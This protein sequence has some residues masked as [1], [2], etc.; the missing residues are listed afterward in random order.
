[1]YILPLGPMPCPR[2]RIALRGRFPTA[3]YPAAY[4]KWKDTAVEALATIRPEQPF[5]GPLALEAWFTAAR[6]KSTKLFAPKPDIDN[7][8]KSLLDALTQSGWWEDDTQVVTVLA[9]KR[10]TP[11]GADPHISFKIDPIP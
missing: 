10:W 7:Y 3:Y 11:T 6:P 2:P 9:W 5:R 4:K 1:M 8:L